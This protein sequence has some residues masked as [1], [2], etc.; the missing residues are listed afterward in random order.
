V[1]RHLKLILA[2]AV[3][4]LMLV[5]GLIST[6]DASPSASQPGHSELKSD[7]PLVAAFE[8][9]DRSTSW[10]LANTVHLGFNVFEPESMEVVGDR[11]YMSAF[12]GSNG[13][14]FVLDQSGNLLKDLTLVDGARTHAGGIDVHGNDLYLPLAEDRPHSS[15]EILKINLTTYQVTTL[16]T[17]ADDHVGG[18]IYN[19][20]TNLIVGQDWGSREFYAW[21]PKGKQVAHWANPE[22]YTDYQDCQYVPSQKMLC[23]GVAGS[24]GGFDLID[25][26]HGQHN[27]LNGVPNTMKTPAGSVLT[28][29]PTDIRAA[30]VAGGT[31][32][33]MYAAPDNNTGT[34]YE[35]TT[36]V[37]DSTS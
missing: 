20:E 34:I 13:H 14:L 27:I 25:L 26:G 4:A 19:P 17:V 9:V 32:L 3:G 33:T 11:I 31:Q 29:N 5:A 10:S 2:T 21:T 23:S 24:L 6:A 7:D 15:A 18:V 22:S 37:P 36:T 12:T 16:F 28:Q 35:Y 8:K 1:N 30:K